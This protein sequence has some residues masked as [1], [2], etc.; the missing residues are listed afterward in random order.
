MRIMSPSCS[1]SAGSIPWL[2][3]LGDSISIHY[4]PYLEG[5]LKGKFRYTRLSDV[6]TAVLNL[7]VGMGGNAGDSN[8]VVQ[9]LS[10]RREEPEFQPDVLLFNCGLHDIKR[11]VARG[12]PLQVEPDKYRSNLVKAVEI[13]R[14]IGSQPVWVRITPV[15]DAIHNN[16][17]IAFRRH[18]ADVDVYNALADEVMNSLKVPAVDLHHFTRQL[19]P[20]E[21][22]FCDHVHFT[23]TI[24][25][26]QAAFIAGWLNGWYSGRS[27]A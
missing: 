27:F 26:K 8:R 15:A 6:E 23:E 7:D 24:R 12:K 3:V 1:H 19:G 4:G 13:I 21:T 18:D 11:E 9:L 14:E 2:Y 5:Y 17:E 16:R 10:M 25:E 20:D 22:L